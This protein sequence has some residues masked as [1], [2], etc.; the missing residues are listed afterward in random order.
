VVRPVEAA[1]AGLAA[2]GHVLEEEEQQDQA[3]DS[4]RRMDMSFYAAKKMYYRLY[5]GRI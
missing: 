2:G 5:A 1:G 3:E 4:G